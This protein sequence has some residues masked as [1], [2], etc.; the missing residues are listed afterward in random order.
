MRASLYARVSTEEQT[1]GYSID[2]Q[3]RAFQVLCQSREWTQHHEYIE[4][5]R[6]AH[7]DDMRKRPVF[8]QAI[9]D[10]LAGKYDV[11][12]VHKI[13][14]FS[15]KLRITLEY[16][17]KLGRA[18]V[19][20][21]SIEN[22][23]DYSTPTGRFTLVM[24]GGLAE[25]YSDNLSQETKKGWAE[26]KAQ[27]LYCGL[28]PFGAKKR[29]KRK[30][31]SLPIPN[32]DTYPGLVMAFEM[33]ADG[34]SYR[35]ITVALN[36]VG[37]RT[38]GNQH[39]GHFTKDTVRTMLQN[40]F[41]IGELP[42]GNG[43]W[44]KAKHKPFVSEELFNAAAIQC[45]LRR[46]SKNVRVR[47]KATTFS[48]SGLAQCAI[49]HQN[50][51][52][53]QN[54]DGKPRLYCRGRAKGW[55]CDFK[56][57]FL[58]VYEEQI[59]WY[60][61]NFLI[62]EGYRERILEA[63]RKLES[64]YDDIEKHRTNLQNRLQRLQ[65]QYEWGHVQKDEYLDKHVQIQRELDGLTPAEA[66]SR[67]LDRLANFLQNVSA[68]WQEATQE[69]RNRLAHTLF[70]E[71]IIDHNKVIGVKP[72]SE[73]KP[74]FQLSYEEHLNYHMRSGIPSGSDAISLE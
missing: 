31:K 22:Q 5:G 21:V 27:G 25:L 66:D 28:L 73:L 26:R 6:S 70:E 7:T 68:A 30:S 48:L 59:A 4:A 41:Y 24:Q 63:H 49:C 46:R 29:N 40:R 20:F 43:S 9:D 32:P 37:Y 69:Q 39:N 33:A 50:I 19:G 2:A 64:A 67:T 58:E 42:D 23:I 62:P 53:H 8:K 71:I 1:E 56:G 17:E 35:E 34:R 3:R 54:H 65:E 10:A 45:D 11:L 15:R 60:L 57:T 38:A 16:F 13:D 55:N 12:V 52:T 18:G 14:R 61:Q 51:A 74:F 44:L 47:R 72:R 36:T